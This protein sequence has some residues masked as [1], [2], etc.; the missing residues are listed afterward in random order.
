MMDFFQLLAAGLSLG[1]IYAL[2]TLSFVVVYKATGIL[3]FA[4]G[5]SV[6]LGA[7]ITYAAAV[8][9]GLPFFVA[10]IISM[11]CMATLGALTERIILR[12]MIG[13]PVFA[14]IMV[15]LGALTVIVNTSSAIWGQDLLAQADPW[16]IN[17]IS[18]GS[19]RVL[20]VDA[21]TV[22]FATIALVVFFL[23][24]RYSRLGLAMRATTLDAE[25][26]LAQGIRV[27][28]VFMIAW[29]MAGAMAALAG[30]MLSAGPRGISIEVAAIALR[31][32]PAMILGGLESPSGAVVG[33][34]VIGVTE[35][36]TAAL[37]SDYQ[38]WVGSNFH[39]VM[40]YIVM[41]VILTLRPYGLFGSKRAERV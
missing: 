1:A 33:G 6:L 34:G 14:I 7:Y 26:A 8:T 29:A 39:V 19:V 32:F 12:K 35:V 18:F 15:T 40:P 31:A 28:H 30:V 16:G 25:A 2:V 24:F 9:W 21:W 20:A 11:I 23:F 10:L 5:G 4:T 3:N 17:T 27:R 41:I 13:Q 22:A 38:G 36:F 37:E